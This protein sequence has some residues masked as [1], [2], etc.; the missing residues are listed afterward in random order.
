MRT[1]KRLAKRYSEIV[2]QFKSVPHSIFYQENEPQDLQPNKLVIRLQPDDGIELTLM[3]KVP[4]LNG[5]PMVLGQQSLKLDFSSV[6]KSRPID[7]YE[8]LLLDFINDNQTLFVRRD[9]VEAAWNW[10]DP[11]INAW[12]QSS[13][14][15]K[16]Y[17]AGSFGPASSLALPLKDGFEWHE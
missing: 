14:P 7:A 2:I 10:V 16:K 12:K 6:E 1:G 3:N 11:I 13:V 5:G 15:A 17:T 8:R 4:S 9:E